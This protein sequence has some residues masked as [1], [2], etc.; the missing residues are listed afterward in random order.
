[1]PEIAEALSVG[2]EVSL[3]QEK[4]LN[5][6]ILLSDRL[7]VIQRI[8][9]L[10]KDRF[11]VGVVSE[12]IKILATSMSSATFRHVSRLCNN[13]AHTL[14]CRAEQFGSCFFRD[15]V[16]DFIRDKLCTI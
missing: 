2:C 13:S 12:D 7:S 15:I 1:V 4:V 11:L 9:S 5:K 3:A 8:N 14:A 6:I 10:V 16:P